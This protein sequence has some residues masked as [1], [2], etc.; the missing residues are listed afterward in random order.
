MLEKKRGHI[1][2]IASTASFHAAPGLVDYCCS[3]VGALFVSE[4]M[5]IVPT[6]NFSFRGA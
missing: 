2:T 3:K 4:G 1:V 6:T 5:Q